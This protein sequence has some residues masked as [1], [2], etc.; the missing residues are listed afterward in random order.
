[1]EL[2]H[3]RPDF[4]QGVGCLSVLQGENDPF[5]WVTHLVKSLISLGSGQ[6]LG[7]LVYIIFGTLNI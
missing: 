4:S 3:D 1:M 2:E 5:L 7:T 6:L